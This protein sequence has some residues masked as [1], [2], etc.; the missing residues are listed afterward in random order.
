MLLSTSLYWVIKT[1]HLPTDI[2]LYFKAYGV[3]WRKKKRIIAGRQN[4]VMVKMHNECRSY[5]R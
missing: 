3:I 5:L 2:M 4:K 1:Q